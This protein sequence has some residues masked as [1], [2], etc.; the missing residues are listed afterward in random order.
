MFRAVKLVPTVTAPLKIFHKNSF[1]FVMCQGSRSAYSIRKSIQYGYPQGES[2]FCLQLHGILFLLYIFLSPNKAKY[3]YQEAPINQ[4][5]C[6]GLQFLHEGVRVG[7]FFSLPLH[8][9][10]KKQVSHSPF[11]SFLCSRSHRSLLILEV[12]MG[13]GAHIT[14]MV[15]LL[16]CRVIYKG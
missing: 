12:V 13:T 11:R 6:L 2:F 5:L 14:Q 3:V 1:I 10:R 9:S 7:F 8:G 4:G 16:N 15:E